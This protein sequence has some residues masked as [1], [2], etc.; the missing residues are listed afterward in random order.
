MKDRQVILARCLT[1]VIYVVCGSGL[2]LLL[3]KNA[4]RSIFEALVHWP[5]LWIAYLF[6]SLLIG[7][8][9][10]RFIKRLHGRRDRE[11]R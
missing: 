4:E 3:W 8:H 5:V 1:G 10:L 6:V 2:Q 9:L 7:E 11:K